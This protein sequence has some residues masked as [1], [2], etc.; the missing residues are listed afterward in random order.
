[1]DRVTLSFRLMSEDSR[2]IDVDIINA[3]QYLLEDVSDKA[4]GIS[5]GQ[6]GLHTEPWKVK[7][8]SSHVQGIIHTS[9]GSLALFKAALFDYDEEKNDE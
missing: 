7:E 3:H 9:G 1:L 6:M 2:T 4:A 5:I 8:E